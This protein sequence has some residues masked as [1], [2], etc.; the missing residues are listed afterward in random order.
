MADKKSLSELTREF[1]LLHEKPSAEEM[2]L[3]FLASF[4]YLKEWDVG[5]RLL[6]T[7]STIT[8]GNGKK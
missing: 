4:R 1:L 6:L 2:L 3:K 5:K 7:E 8:E